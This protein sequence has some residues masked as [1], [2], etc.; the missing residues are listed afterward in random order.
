[1]SRLLVL[2]SS[3][4][5]AMKQAAGAFCAECR[6]IELSFFAMAAP[7]F[8]LG[9]VGKR[10]VFAPHLR[11]R[12]D[13]D[14]IENVN[15]AR[16]IDLTT[17]D[18]IL[19]VGFRFSLSD[20]A[21]LLMDHDILEGSDT[22]KALHCSEAFAQACIDQLVARELS[23]VTN[24]LGQ[25]RNYILTDA[26]YPAVS[27]AARSEEYAPAR[28]LSAFMAHPDAPVLFE[29]WQK[30]VSSAV[31][32]AGYRWLPQPADTVAAPFGTNAD[33]SRD[34]AHIG[35]GGMDTADHRHMNADFGLKMLQAVSMDILENVP[36]T[37]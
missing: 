24:C 35:G 5:A 25:N 23:L 15:G 19:V 27:I 21:W 13:R 29:Y 16:T 7:N 6:D 3:H 32:G 8:R 9:R 26:P 34:A 36:D 37:A 12:V 30:A 22:G 17:F 20:L 1:M 14:F 33:F 18:H 11:S 28:A 2:G 10:G 4:V 31:E